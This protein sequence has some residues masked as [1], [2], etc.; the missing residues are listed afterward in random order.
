MN[1]HFSILVF[2]FNILIQKIIW[3][4]ELDI[5][6]KYYENL[7]VFQDRKSEASS[8]TSYIHFKEGKTEK[9]KAKKNKTHNAQSDNFSVP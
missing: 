9:L 3:N 7:S 6:I 5:L 1:I 8:F 4:L 2:E